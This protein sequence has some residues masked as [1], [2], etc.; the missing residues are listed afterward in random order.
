[1]KKLSIH[2]CKKLLKIEIECL[3]LGHVALKGRN[4]TVG[5]WTLGSDFKHVPFL[6]DKCVKLGF[7]WHENDRNW[8]FT[9]QVKVLFVEFG[10]KRGNEAGLGEYD[11]KYWINWLYFM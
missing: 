1:M 6:S 10:A 3:Q 9:G 7:K 4:V 2:N 5:N 8:S 11:L